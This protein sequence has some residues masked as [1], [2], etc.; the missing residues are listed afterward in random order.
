[1]SLVPFWASHPIKH[2]IMS[3]SWFRLGLCAPTGPASGA[4]A[5]SIFGLL[6]KL[7][8]HHEHRLVPPWAL[9][10][11][12][13]SIMSISW[14]HFGLCAQQAQHHEHQ[15]VPFWSL[16]RNRPSIMSISWF[17][18]GL[19][20]STC[21]ASCHHEHRLVPLRALRPNWPSIM[22]ICLFP[23]GLLRINRPSVKSISFWCFGLYAP[24]SPAS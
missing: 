11:N 14:F 21:P 24:T 18:I 7:A 20:S 9:R 8:Q 23:S 22:S 1:M 6:A 15:L 17:H 4:S 19:C 10:R 13:P 12:R 3:I 5:G 16:R 2:S